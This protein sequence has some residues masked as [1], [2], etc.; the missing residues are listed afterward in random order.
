MGCARRRPGSRPG[1]QAS[2]NKKPRARDSGDAPG[3]ST[4]AG[5]AGIKDPALGRIAGAPFL[6]ADGLVPGRFTKVPAASFVMLMRLVPVGPE[7]PIDAQR[8]AELC[9]SF[10][11]AND[12]VPD[13][14]RTLLGHL[15]D[16]LVVD[17]HDEPRTRL[18]GRE[19]C[20]D[21]DHRA[22]DDV[23]GG[24]LHRRIDR[25]ALGIL[26]QLIVARVDVGQMQAPAEDRADET[27]AARARAGLV[28]V[29]P[30]A[31]VAL[32][33]AGDVVLRL[34]PLDAEL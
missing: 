20:G 14:A 31:G 1:F 2:E 6:G 30:H 28:H 26:A 27:G 8:H 17:L 25:A 32:E 34:T 5:W 21:A 19:P 11:D 23:R 12:I 33:V 15:D 18:L 29:A 3:A 10:H 16:E 22:L 9:R 13:G 7:A 24:S 4:P